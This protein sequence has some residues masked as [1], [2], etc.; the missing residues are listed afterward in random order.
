MTSHYSS[1]RKLEHRKFMAYVEKMVQAAEKAGEAIPLT[2]QA[3]SSS[4]LNQGYPI[5]PKNKLKPKIM[6]KAKGRPMSPRGMPPDVAQ[7]LEEHDSWSEAEHLETM[8]IPAHTEIASGRGSTASSNAEPR[9][10][11]A[12]SCGTP[13]SPEVIRDQCYLCND[14]AGDFDQDELNQVVGV[15]TSPS[16]CLLNRERS[17]MNYLIQKYTSELEE[18]IQNVRPSGNLY[19]LFEV[20]CGEKS[21]ITHQ[22]QKQQGLA[23]RFGLPDDLQSTKGRQHLFTQLVS[24]D[25]ENIWFSPV[26]RPWSAWS[27]FNGHRSQFAWED[28]LSQRYHQL[29]QVALGIVL[30][31]YQKLKGRHMHWEQPQRSLMLKLPY[32]S[33][34]LSQT[35][36]AEFDMCEV[37]DLRDPQ[38]DQLIKKG[39][40]VITTSPKLF[41]HF[42]GHKCSGN[43]QHQQLEGSIHHRGQTMIFRELSPKVCSSGSPAVV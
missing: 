22:C 29:E 36:S 42:H 24:K 1:S 15:E 5:N 30:F 21:Q 4:S 25:P 33:E 6:P 3:G 2:D 31:R 9:D 35:R 23:M 8:D 7:E 18:V 37:G 41:E 20:F 17:R 32:M 12:A 28:L 11:V 10:D 19:D 39:M 40:V 13:D 16:G 26:C 43:H 14:L 34:I 38:T 27:Q